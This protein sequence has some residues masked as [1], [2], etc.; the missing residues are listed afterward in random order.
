MDLF[1]RQEALIVFSEYFP[2]FLAML[3]NRVSE[4]LRF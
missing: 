3:I 4:V 1:T 2:W